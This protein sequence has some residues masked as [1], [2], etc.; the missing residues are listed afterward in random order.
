[1]LQDYKKF[2]IKGN[3]VDL[4]IAVIIGGAF[5]KIVTSMVNDIIMPLLSLITGNIKF[6]NLFIALD[7]NKYATIEEAQVAGAAT[8]NYGLFITAVIDFLIIAIFIFI[9]VSQITRLH[10]KFAK[11][12]EEAPPAVK[13]CPFC[14]TSIH[15]EASRCPNCTSHLDS[16]ENPENDENG[17]SKE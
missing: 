6:A 2:A 16:E 7:G 11:K 17:E 4:A 8:V 5:G 14:K 10:E 9:A 13:D 12:K 1:M 15:K 3:I